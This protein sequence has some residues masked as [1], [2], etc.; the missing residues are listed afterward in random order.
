[1]SDGGTKHSRQAVMKITQK[2][3]WDAE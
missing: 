3:I 1:M 2:A